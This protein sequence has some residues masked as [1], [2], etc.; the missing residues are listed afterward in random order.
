MSP[1]MIARGIVAGAAAVVVLASCS[2]SDWNWLSFLMGVS[3]AQAVMSW[4]TEEQILPF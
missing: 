1:R 4:A 2:V 3:L